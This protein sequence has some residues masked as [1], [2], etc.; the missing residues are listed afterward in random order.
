MPK[1][2][3]S[4]TAVR[5]GKTRKNVGLSLRLAKNPPGKRRRR[6]IVVQLLPVVARYTC[7]FLGC[8]V[9][10][11]V[12]SVSAWVGLWFFQSARSR[13]AVY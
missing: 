9:Y 7:N 11:L 6:Y 8:H 5:I 12:S 13:V 1:N 4:R 10:A 2:I 3:T